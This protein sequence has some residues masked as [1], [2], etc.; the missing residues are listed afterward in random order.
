L[1]KRTRSSL[2]K[3]APKRAAIF[4]NFSKKSQ[5]SFPKSMSPLREPKEQ[6]C[7]WRARRSRCGQPRNKI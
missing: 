2:K 1:L 7:L 6:M 5:L 4:N 3:S